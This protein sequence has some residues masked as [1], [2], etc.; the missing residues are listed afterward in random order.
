M[1]PEN[2]MRQKG[3]ENKVPVNL[4]RRLVIDIDTLETWTFI[5]NMSTYCSYMWYT[6]IYWNRIILIISI[7]G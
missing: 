4:I 6:L 7:S 2:Q 1:S 5:M 3:T